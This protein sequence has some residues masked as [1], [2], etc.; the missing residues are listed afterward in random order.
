MTTSIYPRGSGGPGGGTTV[1]VNAGRLW[2]GGLATA[3][4]AGLVVLVGILIARGVFGVAIP[5]PSASGGMSAFVYVLIAIGA[6]LGATLLLYVLL[7]G[8]PRPLAFF[9]WIVVLATIVAALAPFSNSILGSAANVPLL[10][11]KVSVALINLVA[12]IAIGSLLT[13]VARSS[14]TRVPLSPGPRQ[15]PPS[16]DVNDY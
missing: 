9:T 10:T 8:A 16:A 5:V 3:V 12:G 13:G 6:A 1:Q 15:Y 14:L 7:L 11:S 2:A 4:I